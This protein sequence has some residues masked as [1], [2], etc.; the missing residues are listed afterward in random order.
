MTNKNNYNIFPLR[1]Y[2]FLDS[3]HNYRGY[4]VVNNN[5]ELA[6][7]IL[8]NQNDK[9]VT[10]F[11]DLP[12]LDTYGSF[13]ATV[14]N[15]EEH[16][17]FGATNYKPWFFEEFKPLLLSIEFSEPKLTEEE[18]YAKLCVGCPREYK[19]HED[20]THCDEFLIALEGGE[21]DA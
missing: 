13:V 16:F 8:A 17:G 19:C 15:N 10:D 20:C 6:I 9:L 2:T 11:M 4:E 7:K 5:E 12:V 14:Y 3:S 1:V 21:E 18:V